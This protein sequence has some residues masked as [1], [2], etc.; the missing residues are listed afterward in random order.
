[1]LLPLFRNRKQKPKRLLS[2]WMAALMVLSAALTSVASPQLLLRLV[3]EEKV[4]Y[5]TA[6]ESVSG[7]VS[8]PLDKV[9]L[10]KRTAQYQAQHR[11]SF[12]RRVAH[13][14]QAAII[15]DCIRFKTRVIASDRSQYPQYYPSRLSSAENAQCSPRAPPFVLSLV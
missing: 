4:G 13:A 6:A 12:L 7:I 8:S 11:F 5:V 2:F 15:P 9:P 1:M 10:K 3:E 14:S